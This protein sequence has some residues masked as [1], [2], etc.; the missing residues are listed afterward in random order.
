MHRAALWATV[1]ASWR[2][3]TH[4]LPPAS[5]A[6]RVTWAGGVSRA[7]WGDPSE[8]A[9]RHLQRSAPT[10]PA[11]ARV[12]LFAWCA[13]GKDTSPIG[14]G[15]HPAPG[16]RVLTHYTCNALCQNKVPFWGAAH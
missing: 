3:G 14:L 2:P 5:C 9:P 1:A 8:A 6:L 10:T 13:W 16:D 12:C 4:P 11:W 15:T 7:G